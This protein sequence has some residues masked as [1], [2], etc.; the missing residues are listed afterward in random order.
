MQDAV[1]LST[2]MGWEGEE[3]GEAIFTFM[4]YQSMSQSSREKSSEA[5]ENFKTILGIT[6]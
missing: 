2:A 4:L 1:K 5:D 3:S 6:K